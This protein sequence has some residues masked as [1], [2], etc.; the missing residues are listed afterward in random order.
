MSAIALPLKFKRTIKLAQVATTANDTLRKREFLAWCLVILL[1]ISHVYRIP[2]DDNTTS[3]AT[4]KL[5]SHQS[6]DSTPE[7]VYHLND[8]PANYYTQK[9]KAS[10]TNKSSYYDKPIIY[11]K[12]AALVRRIWHSNSSPSINSNLRQGSCWCSADEW[13]VC[14]PALAVDLILT[15]GPDHVWLVRRE[16]TG[17]LALMGGFTEVGETSE[18]SARRELMEEMN[19]QMTEED[20]L[21]LFGV[22]N[23]PQRDER[24][25]TTSIVYILDLP[26]NVKPQAGDDAKEVVRLPLEEVNERDFF[27]D[28]KTVLKDYKSFLERKMEQNLEGERGNLPPGPYSGDREPFKRSVCPM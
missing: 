14:T 13:C 22:Y 28:H 12:D 24:R 1:G 18:E 5:R 11:S 4:P 15:S 3:I 17:L 21:Q 7:C 2:R 27:I 19:I 6:A 9:L 25:H 8:R 16:D 10:Q 26:L 23:D 20:T